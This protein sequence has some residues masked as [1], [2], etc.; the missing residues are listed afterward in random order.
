M[1]RPH[2]TKPNDPAR[3]LLIDSF[4]PVKIYY[5]VNHKKEVTMNTNDKVSFAVESDSSLIVV[6]ANITS[7]AYDEVS[8]QLAIS[9]A[10]ETW[11]DDTLVGYDAWKS[12]GEC[13]NVQHLQ[14]YWRNCKSGLRKYMEAVGVE[15]LTIETYPKHEISKTWDS[16]KVI[17][18]VEDKHVSINQIVGK[19]VKSVTL[20][21]VDGEFGKEPC[22]NLHFTD[23]KTHGFVVLE[24]G[25]P[26]EFMCKVCE[27]ELKN[28]DGICKSCKAE[29]GK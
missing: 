24:D 27:C 13:F 4:D 26:P 9:N 19:T 11:I 17:V 10:L 5:D 12:S 18:N 15:N 22:I 7:R 28:P 6:S 21:W 20:S 3:R 29:Y 2:P 23:G 8:L 1:N 25:L 14:H 16:E